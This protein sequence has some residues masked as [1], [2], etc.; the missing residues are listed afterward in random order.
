MTRR[1]FCLSLGKVTLL[2]LLIGRMF[3]L[4][5]LKKDEYRI[6]SD[7]NRLKTMLISPPRGNIYDFY[8]QNIAQNIA[9]FRLLLDKNIT[10]D[11]RQE[12]EIIT[13]LLELDTEQKSEFFKRVNNTSWKIAG[14]IIDSLTWQQVSILEERKSEIKSF[15]VDLGFKRNYLHS[16]A[17]AHVTGYLGKQSNNKE[18]L[19]ISD[20]YWRVGK[21]GVESYYEEILRGKF[22]VKTIEV[23]AHGKYVRDLSKTEVIP[24]LPL[25]LNLNL[26]L[27]SKAFQYLPEKGCSVNMMD[28]RTGAMILYT[29]APSFDPNEFYKLSNEYWQ[30][31]AANPYKPLIDKCCKSLYPPGSVFKIVTFLAAL[32]SNISP[33]IKIFCSG[34][35]ELGGNSFRCAKATG[36]GLITMQEAIKYSCNSYVFATARKVGAD[37]I[38]EVA[39]K[40]GFG[41]LTGIDIAGEKEGFVPSPMWKY[42]KYKQRWTLGDTLNMSIGQGFLLATPLQITRMMAAIANGGYL[43]TPTFKQ[44]ITDKTKLDIKDEHLKF[45]QLALHD[46][47]NKPGGTGYSSRVEHNSRTIAAKTGTAQVRAKKN[48]HDDLNRE[49]IAW[50]SRNHAIFSGYGP[51]EDPQFAMTVYFDHGGG[52]GR[53]AAPIAKKIIMDLFNSGS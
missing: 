13:S 21:T 24:G 51:F 12:G 46:V 15:F 17:T 35:S 14:L 47:M 31:L 29:S 34:K 18:K 50:E 40:L 25:Q 45:L 33:D 41:Q 9:C 39:K 53:S 32:E 2:S 26:A 28:C 38:I 1:I 19:E 20:E 43:L 30:N 8:G 48:Q 16:H 10:P 5:F 37:K 7:K 4:Q 3:Y 6:L 44:Q 36:H 22:G 23:N 52:G 27:Q 49:S 11:F 42:K